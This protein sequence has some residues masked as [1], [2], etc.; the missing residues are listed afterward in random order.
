MGAILE[1]IFFVLC[2]SAMQSQ[3]TLLVLYQALWQEDA[4]VLEKTHFICLLVPD[5]QEALDTERTSK[6]F[7]LFFPAPCYGTNSLKKNPKKQTTNKKK[8]DFVV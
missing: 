6:L 3:L 8:T 1:H 5:F 2:I 4:Q 7:S